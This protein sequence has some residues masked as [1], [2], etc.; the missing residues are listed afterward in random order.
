MLMCGE[1]DANRMK[2]GKKTMNQRE[3]QL[4]FKNGSSASL[5]K[6]DIFGYYEC[7]LM[8]SFV[9]QKHVVLKLR[10]QKLQFFQWTSEA[11]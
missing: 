9:K 8:A 3:S 6:S 5:H 4:R 7:L 1:G 11:R 2:A 10:A